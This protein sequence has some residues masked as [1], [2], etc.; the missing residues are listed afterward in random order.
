[1]NIE[2]ETIEY[3]KN[4]LALTVRKDYRITIAR[5]VIH[6]AKRVSLKIS[7]SILLLNFLNI[8]I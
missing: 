5:N 6:T 4:C 3:A 2:E 1:M 8:I 7:L